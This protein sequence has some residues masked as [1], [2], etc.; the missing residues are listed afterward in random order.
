MLQ[1]KQARMMLR[2]TKKIDRGQL[3]HYEVVDEQ[4]W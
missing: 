4:G 3:L 1:R 2:R